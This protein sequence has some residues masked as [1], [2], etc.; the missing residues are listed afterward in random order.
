[1]TVR[2]RLVP[3]CVEIVNATFDVVKKRVKLSGRCGGWASG[4][5]TKPFLQPWDDTAQ[6]H[7]TF[8]YLD[9]R[10]PDSRTAQHYNVCVCV[11]VCVS[12]VCV[13]L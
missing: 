13:V 11:C 4:G 10:K 1:V 8:V 5:K 9:Y 7:T 3:V 2:V 6:R 12:I